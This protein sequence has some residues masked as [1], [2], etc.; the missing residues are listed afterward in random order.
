M[1]VTPSAWMKIELKMG[2][3][4]KIHSKLLLSIHNTLLGVQNQSCRSKIPYS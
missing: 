3:M 1:R 2:I 4:Q